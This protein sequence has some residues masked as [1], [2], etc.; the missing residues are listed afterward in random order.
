MSASKLHPL[1]VY[2]KVLAPSGRRLDRRNFAALHCSG[3]ATPLQ[4]GWDANDAGW[5]CEATHRPTRETGAVCRSGKTGRWWA[6]V[7]R[8]CAPGHPTTVPRDVGTICMGTL[9]E[10]VRCVHR[11]ALEDAFGILNLRY[12]QAF[13]QR[14]SWGVN[15][16]REL[17]LTRGFYVA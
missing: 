9:R 3:C 10:G 14:F 7:G 4:T 16:R 12:W 8:R 15:E 2:E 5:V 1:R 11:K 6:L 17:H 13:A